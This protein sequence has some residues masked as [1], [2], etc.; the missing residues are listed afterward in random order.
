VP[1]AA[2]LGFIVGITTMLPVIG[3]FLGGGLATLLALLSQPLYAVF[4][5]ATFVGVQQIET[6]YQTPRV[7]SR[8]IGID[9]ILVI[10]AV[11]VGFALAGV[12]GALIAVPIVGIFYIVL[13][14]WIIEPRKANMTPYTIQDGLIVLNSM[15]ETDEKEPQKEL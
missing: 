14:R 13:R 2:T 15:N 8:S 4:T 12:I 6:H 1:N 10:V 5:F 11:F 3:G 7:M 9:P